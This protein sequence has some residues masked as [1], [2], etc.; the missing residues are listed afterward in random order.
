MFR[1][2]SKTFDSFAKASAYARTLAKDEGRSVLLKRCCAE[3]R[4]YT[5][6]CRCNNGRE[7]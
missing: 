5:V 1:V 7:A 4:K 2:E 3:C 6:E